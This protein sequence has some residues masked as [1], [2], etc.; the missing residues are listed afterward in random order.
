[1]SEHVQVLFAGDADAARALR[2]RLA[3]LPVRAFDA[4]DRALAA[5]CV[6]LLPHGEDLPARVAVLKGQ[7]P[8]V[9][10]VVALRTADAPALRDLLDAGADAVVAEGLEAAALRGAMAALIVPPTRSR[11]GAREDGDALT[12]RESEVLRLLSAGFSNKE[13][14]RRLEVSVRT[15]ETHRLNLRRKTRTGRLRDLVQLARRLGLQPVVEG[16]ASADRRS[17]VRRSMSDARQAVRR[18]G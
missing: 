7:A 11:S 6:I 15:V 18:Y 4:A 9:P 8:G 1:M 13:V 2:H 10:V 12:P 16:G 14:A 17:G 5:A 3:P